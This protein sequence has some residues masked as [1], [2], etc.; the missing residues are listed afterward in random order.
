MNSGCCRVVFFGGSEVFQFNKNEVWHG[1]KLSEQ[2]ATLTLCVM[3]ILSRTR[4]HARMLLNNWVPKSEY[5]IGSLYTLAVI[6]NAQISAWPL[7]SELGKVAPAC[8]LGQL[9][10]MGSSR[11]QLRDGGSLR[12]SSRKD[13]CNGGALRQGPE[14]VMWRP[15]WAKTA[16]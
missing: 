6:P 14:E 13:P 8:C 3:S 10:R 7:D 5:Q 4:L 12:F 11:G 2:S 1:Q 9:R 16:R 15:A